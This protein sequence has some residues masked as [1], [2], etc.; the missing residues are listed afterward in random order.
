MWGEG[1]GSKFPVEKFLS[2]NA[3]KFRGAKHRVSLISGFEKIFASDGYVSN[4]SVLCFRSFPVA[5]IL[6][7]RRGK[8]I[9]SVENFWSHSDE[10]FRSRTLYGVT[11]FR[12]RKTLCLRG[13]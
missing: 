12:Y 10:H 2:H 6:S 7:I 9:F 5:K 11:D 1:E 13:F 8:S 4:P 3:E